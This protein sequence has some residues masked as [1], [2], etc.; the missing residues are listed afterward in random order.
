MQLATSFRISPSTLAHVCA[1]ISKRSRWAAD[2]RN[3]AY[4][5]DQETGNLAMVMNV[6]GHSDVS[7]AIRYQHPIFDSVSE[8]HRPA[9]LYVTI[10]VTMS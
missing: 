2:H 4:G 1:S 5:N 8:G 6:M 7:T 9:Q 10:H 3:P